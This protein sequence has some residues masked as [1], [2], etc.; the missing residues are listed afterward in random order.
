M[1]PWLKSRYLM[2]LSV[3]RR[4]PRRQKT[5]A[6]ISGRCHVEK[7]VVDHHEVHAP[8]KRFAKSK[9]SLS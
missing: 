7:S 5:T 6:V 1:H 3:N 8:F 4:T 9:M 2:T